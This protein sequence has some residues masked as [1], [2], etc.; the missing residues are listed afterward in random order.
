[1]AK[2][3]PVNPSSWPLFHTDGRTD[4]RTGDATLTLVHFPQPTEKKKKEMGGKSAKLH[5]LR[6]CPSFRAPEITTK[7]GGVQST[8][9]K[10]ANRMA[11]KFSG[12]NF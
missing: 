6:W 8:L 7:D 2:Y 1:M 9:Q 12:S 3:L 5:P 10:Y 4:K 11:S